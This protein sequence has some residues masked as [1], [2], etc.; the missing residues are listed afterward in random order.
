M[1]RSLGRFEDELESLRKLRQ[2][3]QSFCQSLTLEQERLRQAM[4]EKLRSLEMG[5]QE[6]GWGNLLLMLNVFERQLCKLLFLFSLGTGPASGRSSKIDPSLYVQE[7]A[8]QNLAERLE[9]VEEKAGLLHVDVPEPGYFF[10][11][12]KGTGLV[13]FPLFLL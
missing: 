13:T 4:S 10:C 3:E 9:F 7:S 12:C 8:Q 6:R 5:L 1:R 2:G 11:L